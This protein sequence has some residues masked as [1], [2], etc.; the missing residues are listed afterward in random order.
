M[1]SESVQYE[2]K[3]GA[4]NYHDNNSNW[5]KYICMVAFFVTGS[6]EAVIIKLLYIQKV[7]GFH[8]IIKHFERPWF[9]VWIMFFTMSLHFFLTPFFNTFF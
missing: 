1:I 5:Q 7:T 2:W 4:F 6:L 9:Q 3:M 8:N